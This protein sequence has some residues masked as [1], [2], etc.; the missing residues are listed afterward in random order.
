[1]TERFKRILEILQ[2]NWR[3]KLG[4]LAIA[5]LLYFN[6]QNSKILIK[7]YNIPVEYPK[8]T[9]NMSL[10]KQSDKTL[11]VRVR[12]VREYVNYYSQFM[13]AQI[14]STNLK[15][16]ENI[17]PVRVTGVPTGMQVTKLKKYVKVVVDA[18]SSKTVPIEVTFSDEP[19]KEYIR[20]SYFYTPKKVTLHGSESELSGIRKLTLPP[21][22][23]TDRKKPFST[24]IKIPELPKGV[25]IRRG[26]KEVSL[27][28]N[29]VESSS[30]AGEETILAVPLSCTGLDP[31]LE[32][33]FSESD[34]AIKV[35]SKKAVKSLD[36]IKGLEV[37]VSCSSHKLDPKSGKILP[38]EKPFSAKVKVTKKKNLK[39]V[40]ILEVDPEKV[41][42]T[43]H[44]LTAAE[45]ETD[46]MA[47]DGEQDS[48][49]ETEGVV[50]EE[51]T[52]K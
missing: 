8:L 27:R 7:E 48:A 18:K 43:F 11:P 16:G 22:S 13:K 35:V 46:T 32:A 29:I 5:I 17:V 1:M 15:V 52:T 39:N 38:D 45:D 37:S 4:S 3:A 50:P 10:S 20:A 26:G 9:G 12:G 44:K 19:P 25:E 33:E 41:T 6:L 34:V 36:I 40:E 47:P 14:D 49:D 2:N 31:K 28:V 42:I 30:E 23:L 24:K 51:E 21:V